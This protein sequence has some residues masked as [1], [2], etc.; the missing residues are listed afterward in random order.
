VSSSANRRYKRKI[1]RDQKK[2]IIPQ[3]NLQIPSLEEMA[4]YIIEK[5]QAIKME[6]PNKE[7]SIWDVTA[8]NLW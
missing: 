7:K 1:A 4:E 3:M 2:G 6:E 8:K 5:K